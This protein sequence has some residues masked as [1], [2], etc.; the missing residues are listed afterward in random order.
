M[1]LLADGLL[2]MATLAAAAYCIVLSR[3]LAKL[4]GLDQGVG[5]AIVSLS[6]RVDTLSATLAEAKQATEASAEA[7]SARTSAASAAADRLEGLLQTSGGTTAMATA[8]SD[9][10]PE[11]EARDPETGLEASSAPA[12]A[13]AIADTIEIIRK[14][15]DL[16][17]DDAFAMRLVDALS[18]L[19]PDRRATV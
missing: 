3:R 6:E 18:A 15:R 7:L 1:S 12:P 19:Q 8:T 10:S 2:I 5:K 17:D 4:N 11:E 16:D 14:S 13:A 9:T